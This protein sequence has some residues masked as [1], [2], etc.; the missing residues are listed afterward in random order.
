MNTREQYDTNEFFKKELKRQ[1]HKKGLT[2]LA[3]SKRLGMKDA[4][5]IGHMEHDSNK[6][7]HASIIMSIAIAL[8]LGSYSTNRL[9]A[10][11]GFLPVELNNKWPMAM[12]KCMNEYIGLD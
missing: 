11:A 10:S 4:A 5:Y 1:R 7:H 3:L 8:E 2:Q 6:I 12:Q 9:L